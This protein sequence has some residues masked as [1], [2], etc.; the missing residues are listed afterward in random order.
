MK[1]ALIFLALAGVA[2][3]TACAPKPGAK[4]PFANRHPYRVTAE[5][6]IDRSKIDPNAKPA[7]APDPVYFSEKSGHILIPTYVNGQRS[8]V[9]S[10]EV[11]Q[12]GH[13]YYN[14][15]TGERMK[16][17]KSA[18]GLYRLNP[19]PGQYVNLSASQGPNFVGSGAEIKSGN[20]AF[21][22]SD[23]G[24][25]SSSSD[26]RVYIN[27]NRGYVNFADSMSEQEARAQASASCQEMGLSARSQPAVAMPNG[28]KN[29]EFVCA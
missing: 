4:A 17:E 29:L 21:S 13:V 9:R 10:N 12:V 27:D 14:A 5:R 7:E 24:L 11:L 15:A 2:A 22:N 6:V 19:M 16:A 1:Y 20:G 23:V 8:F 25:S 28:S 3:T 26:L 18:E